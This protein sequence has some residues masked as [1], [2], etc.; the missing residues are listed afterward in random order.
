MCEEI[1]EYVNFIETFVTYILVHIVQKTKMTVKI[2][3]C[4][5]IE[6]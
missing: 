5:R 1:Y 3:E 6:L 2:M 4:L